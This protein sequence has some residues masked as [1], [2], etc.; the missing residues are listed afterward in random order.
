MTRS[1]TARLLVLLLAATAFCAA[2]AVALR[3]G[4]IDLDDTAY[5]T[6][7]PV[8]RMGL[9]DGALTPALRAIAAGLEAGQAPGALLPVARRMAALSGAGHV[10]WLGALAGMMLA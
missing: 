3:S 1:L 7:N 8:V 4:F 2:Y 9:T 5:V 10:A 6:E